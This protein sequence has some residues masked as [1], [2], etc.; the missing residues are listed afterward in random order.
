MSANEDIVRRV[1]LGI[2]PHTDEQDTDSGVRVVVNVAAVHVPSVLKDGYK[3]RYDLNKAPIVGSRQDKRL[4][5]DTAVAAIDGVTPAGLYYAAMEL[6]GAGMR[7]YGDFGMVLKTE[8]IDEDQLV[9]FMNS[10]DI[11]REP[12]RGRVNGDPERRAEAAREIAGGWRDRA[13]MVWQKL[14]DNGGIP[15]A[16]LISSAAVSHG[17]LDDEDYLEVPLSGSFGSGNVDHVR[18]AAPD[19][20]REAAITNNEARRGLTQSQWVSQRRHAADALDAARIGV[21]IVGHAG[22]Q[23]T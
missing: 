11:E 21:V 20:A 10:F 1:V 3:N 8:R 12:L 19:A 9:L 18:T 23:R 22:R 17:V 14:R 2:D 15:Q 7:F 16:R 6:N 13:E 5:V 4:D